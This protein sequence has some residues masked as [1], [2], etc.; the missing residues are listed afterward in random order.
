MSNLSAALASRIDALPP[1]LSVKILAD[2]LGK[3]VETVRQQIR[4][5]VFPIRVNQIDGGEQY[6]TLNDLI[7][8]LEDGQPQSQ[9]PLV[10]RAARNPY[11]RHGKRGRGRPTNAERVAR[12]QMEGGA[13]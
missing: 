4:R 10:K 6:V 12:S 7:K 3:K 13:Q 5:N 9:P 11:G 8:F 1:I 2:F